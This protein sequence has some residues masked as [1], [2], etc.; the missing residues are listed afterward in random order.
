MV[1]EELYRTVYILKFW[2]FLWRL[3]SQMVN[4][5]FFH[6]WVW[7]FSPWNL[8]SLCLAFLAVS[9]IAVNALVI[10]SPSNWCDYLKDLTWIY[11]SL[12]SP[13]CCWMLHSLMRF[14]LIIIVL[15][16]FWASIAGF[17][18]LSAA[19]QCSPILHQNRLVY[20]FKS[21][22]WFMVLIQIRKK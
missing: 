1:I 11:I 6:R 12:L 5:L 7:S 3:V 17:A 4:F 15:G 20:S 16:C 10:F 13:I 21:Y 22:L 8:S 2:L 19:V 18:S 9:I 14:P